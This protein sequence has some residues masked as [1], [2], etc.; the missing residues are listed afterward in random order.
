MQDKGDT[1]LMIWKDDE[2]NTYELIPT[3]GY[4]GNREGTH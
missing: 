2:Y 4:L 1:K 3:S